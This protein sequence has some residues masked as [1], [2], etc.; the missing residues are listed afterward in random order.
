MAT[1]ELAEKPVLVEIGEQL[2]HG[3]LLEVQLFAVLGLEVVEC[4][5][6]RQLLAAYRRR[7]SI[8]SGC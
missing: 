1:V 6:A 8:H 5:T 3:A 4:A 2:D 7:R